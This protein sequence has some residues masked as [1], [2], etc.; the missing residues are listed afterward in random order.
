AG[1]QS[2]TKFRLR[3]KGVPR[4]NGNGNGDEYV[5]VHVKTPKTL[6]KR[7]REAMLAFAAASGEDV[8]GVKAGFFDKL[9]DAFEDNK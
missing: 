2:E 4:V 3:G 6:N 5:T 9:K 1:T 8:K 7:Q